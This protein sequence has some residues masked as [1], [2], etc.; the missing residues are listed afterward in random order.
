MICRAT[1]G[2]V[3]FLL[4]IRKCGKGEKPNALCTALANAEADR[5]SSAEPGALFAQDHLDRGLREGTQSLVLPLP[6]ICET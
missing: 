5:K 3:I 6:A 2:S 1:N 4:V